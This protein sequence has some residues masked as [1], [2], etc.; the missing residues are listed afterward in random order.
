M[1]DAEQFLRDLMGGLQMG[2]AAQQ[3]AQERQVRDDYLKAQKKVLDAQFKQQEIE[4]QFLDQVMQAQQGGGALPGFGGQP[5]DG[6]GLPDIASK[7]ILGGQYEK[8][9]GA[10]PFEVETTRTIA[11]PGGAPVSQG[12]GI[13]GQPIGP[14]TPEPVRQ[15]PR[16]FETPEGQF[17]EFVSPFT[18]GE[19]VR[20]GPPK[21]QTQAITTVTN[22][23]PKMR[24]DAESSA[25]AIELT[26]GLIEL[27]KGGSV[28]G[29]A[30]QIKA[31][32]APY[33]E[34]LGIDPGTFSDAQMFQLLA[35]AN[36]GRLRLDIIGPGPVSEFEQK[37]MQTI[38]GGGGA[39]QKAAVELLNNWRRV[40]E[41]KVRTYNRTAQ[42]VHKFVPA[43]KE[44]F[45][46]ISTKSTKQPSLG[47]G[48]KDKP[49]LSSFERQ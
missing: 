11:G 42:G 14:Q 39:A 2:Q 1:P 16:E 45:P 18:P 32:A 19:A 33:V 27:A 44:L 4:N 34:A 6:Q 41:S 46:T 8:A 3:Q 43:T 26:D 23:L 21:S 7:L 35:R 48:K 25:T 28:T 40:A 22:Q 9:F 29:K 24:T 30:G 38:S 5:T 31:W 20:V 37:L 17:Q 36:I 12:F 15:I 10:S 49:P 47:L 13:F